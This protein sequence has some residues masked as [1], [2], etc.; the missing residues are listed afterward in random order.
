MTV[1]NCPECDKP[2]VLGSRY[3]RLDV[4][5]EKWV[6]TRSQLHESGKYITKFVE[7]IL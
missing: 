3:L 2:M 4:Q 5:L 1:P 6:C 7:E